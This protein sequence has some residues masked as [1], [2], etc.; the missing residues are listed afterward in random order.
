MPIE[1]GSH[2]LGPDNGSLEV[3]TLREGMA[4]KVGHDLIIEVRAWEGTL[5]IAEDPAQSTLALSADPRSLHVR[6]GLHGLKPLSDKDRAEIARTSTRRSWAPTRSP[7]APVTWS[8]RTTAT[9]SRCME[10]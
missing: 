6:E 4:S 5:A 10:T 2:Q 1:T 3:R 8:S 7:C 9:A